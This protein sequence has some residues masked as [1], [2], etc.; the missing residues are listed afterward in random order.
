MKSRLANLFLD[1]ETKM[2]ENWKSCTACGNTLLDENAPNP[3]PGPETETREPSAQNSRAAKP[4]DEESPARD[5]AL[6]VE[7]KDLDSF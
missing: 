4:K 1:N 7:I 6:A 2:G 3:K 5:S